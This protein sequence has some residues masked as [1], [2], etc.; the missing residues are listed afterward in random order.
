MDGSVFVKKISF[1]MPGF[2]FSFQLDGGFYIIPINKTA[3]K[4]IRTL[5]CYM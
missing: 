4:K 2:S 1:K 5:I 3:S